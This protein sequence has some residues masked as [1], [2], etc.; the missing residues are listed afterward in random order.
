MRMRRQ[1]HSKSWKRLRSKPC[2]H[3]EMLP[4]KLLTCII[5]KPTVCN[6]KRKMHKKRRSVRSKI[7]PNWRPSFWKIA[8]LWP[9]KHWKSKLL[10][11][12]SCWRRYFR[13]LETR[14]CSRFGSWYRRL[15]TRRSWWKCLRNCQIRRRT[16]GNSLKM[17]R[18]IVRRWKHSSSATKRVTLWVF[19][20]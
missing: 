9:L 13:S 10:S 3:M 6:K 17:R 14:R 5:L 19:N 7:K 18:I 16:C 1:R 2:S 4:S 15:R 8:Q 12:N 20:P 11:T